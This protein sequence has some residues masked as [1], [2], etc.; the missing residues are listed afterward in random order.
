ME[1]Q[2]KVGF[3]GS[4]NMA[5]AISR[6]LIHSGTLKAQEVLM[7]DV[8]ES[9]LKSFSELGTAITTDAG[10]VAKN[11]Q[12]VFL[13]VKPQSLSDV[14]TQLSGKWWCRT[15]ISMLAGVKRQRIK[16]L[17]N[18]SMPC[19]VR[20]MP[21]LACEHGKGVT[22]VEASDAPATDRKMIYSLLNPL[23]LTVDLPEK[24]FNAGTALSGCGPAFFYLIFGAF[25]D[26]GKKFGLDAEMVKK[27]VFATAEGSA[28]NIE[29]SSLPLDEMVSMV[30]SKGGATI[31][32][33]KILKE[34]DV[35]GTIRRSV[36]ASKQKSDKLENA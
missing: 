19:V 28:K 3:I 6:R 16:E 32:G 34:F 15:V 12:I 11:A 4:G 30:C 36:A 31:E 14:M 26:A 2:Y 7:C 35:P 1:H 5:S 23:G 13:A 20:I 27:L 29:M 9:A 25:I 24:Q 10:E 21:N 8:N 22:L 17:L 33:V 18:A